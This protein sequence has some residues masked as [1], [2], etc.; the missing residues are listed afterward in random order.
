VA[1]GVRGD[2]A[3]IKLLEEE[4][5]ADGVWGNTFADHPMFLWIFEQELSANEME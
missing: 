4:S 5:T 1:D 3:A 2:P